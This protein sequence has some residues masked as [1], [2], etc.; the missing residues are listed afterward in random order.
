MNPNTLLWLGVA[1]M[2]LGSI[3]GALE[4]LSTKDSLLYKVGVVLASLGI[5]VTSLSKLLGGGK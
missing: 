4:Q 3:G 2:V 5:D 1:S